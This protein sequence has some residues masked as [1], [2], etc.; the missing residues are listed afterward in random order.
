MSN[1]L[2]KTSPSSAFLIISAVRWLTLVCWNAACFS[3]F[4]KIPQEQSK[5]LFGSCE[6]FFS[7]AGTMC[8]LYENRGQQLRCSQSQ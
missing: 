6:E 3:Y 5:K 1:K 2:I 8:Q 4:Y 7:P